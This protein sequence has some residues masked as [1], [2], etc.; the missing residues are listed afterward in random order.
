M[1]VDQRSEYDFSRRRSVTIVD[2][3]IVADEAEYT[4]GARPK[5]LVVDFVLHDD[6]FWRAVVPLSGIT[7][8]AGQAF[9]FSKPKTRSGP[10]G[11]EVVRD[12]LGVPRPTLRTLNHVQCRFRFEPAS[13]VLLFPLESDCTGPPAHTIDDLVYS[14][15]AVGPPGVT[16][17]FRDAIAG[18]L[19]CAHR[20]L[21]TQEMVFERIAV[22]SQ[23]V[24][25]AAPLPLDDAQ[26][27]GLLE[28]A[29]RRSA[30][31]GLTE[32]YFLYRCCGA[33]NCTSN[34]FQILDRYA[35]YGPLQ[36]LGALL[37][38]FPLSPRFYLRLRGL[39]SNPRQRTL[40]RDEFTSFIDAP[41]TQQRK[42]DYVR[43]Q[44][45]KSGRKRKRRSKECEGDENSSES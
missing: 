30:A 10:G 16:F 44:I 8:A 23:Y 21:S 2:D 24:V 26:R 13:P 20:F 39:D 22:E 12:A 18:T 11:P 28:A 31:A 7:S 15:E 34:A 32:R 43:A 29:L 3:P 40:V 14:V 38:R 17:N 6:Q 45:A 9:N 35:K 33:N 27:A 42:R 37:Y 25:E 4:A 36:R 1:N 41:A 19:M 5:R